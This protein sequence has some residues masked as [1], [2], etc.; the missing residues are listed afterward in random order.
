M[1]FGFWGFFF[2]KRLHDQKKSILCLKKSLAISGG[3]NTWVRSWA[4]F[5]HI[6]WWCLSFYF[7]RGDS[8][9]IY[10]DGVTPPKRALV[11][12]S[13]SSPPGG[14]LYAKAQHHQRLLQTIR[15]DDSE[16]RLVPLLSRINI[17]KVF[18]TTTVEAAFEADPKNHIMAFLWNG[19][20]APLP[21]LSHRP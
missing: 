20:S 21:P 1:L 6:W 16:S 3:R 10:L 2:Y 4:K 12:R 11:S 15:E 5:S 17:V 8:S 7:S 18:A 14:N 19:C 9:I 13:S